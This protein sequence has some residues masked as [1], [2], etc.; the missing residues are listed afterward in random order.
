MMQQ[1]LYMNWLVQF[2]TLF[3]GKHAICVRYNYHHTSVQKSETW[4]RKFSVETHKLYDVF[5]KVNFQA[6]QVRA[7]VKAT[8]A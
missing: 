6:Q 8:L 5:V 3:V 1:K 2:R 7:F 4:A